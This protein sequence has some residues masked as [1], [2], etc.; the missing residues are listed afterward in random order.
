MSG[1]LRDC[2]VWQDRECTCAE[3]VPPAMHRISDEQNAIARDVYRKGREFGVT[4][5]LGRAPRRVHAGSDAS[6]WS[7]P[8]L[9]VYGDIANKAAV[10]ALASGWAGDV[11]FQQR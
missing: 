6:A 4:G 10:I 5:I 2:P 1:H 3:R 7:R 11:E 8:T 9:I